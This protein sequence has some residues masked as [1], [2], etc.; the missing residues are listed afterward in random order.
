MAGFPE[1]PSAWGGL[2]A[3][4]DTP[5]KRAAAIGV[6]LVAMA[7]APFA[8][9]TY[10]TVILTNA[11]LYVLLAL[12]LNIVVGYA[13]LLDLG[14]AAFF[15]VGAYTVGITTLHF[16]LSFWLALP[17]AVLIAIIAGIVIGAPTLRLRSDY[18]AIVTLGFGEIV[19]ITARNLRET[20]GASGLIGIDSPWLFGWHIRTPLDFYYVFCVLAILGVIASARL[21]NSRLG[22]AWLYVRH[23][24]DAAEAMGINRVKVKLAAYVVGAIYGSIGG[25]FFAANL[26]AISPESFSF[27]QSVLILMAVILGGM[28]KIPGVI[29]GAFIVILAPELLRDAGDM[30]LLIFAVGLLLI[31]LFRP[32]GIWPARSKQK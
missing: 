30:R 8:F 13:G 26:G 14:F 28:G 21:A 25:A 17:L 1:R 31:M 23:D 27:R 20:G 18:L 11:L 5:A 22:R 9:G 2:S 19:R 15:A 3:I 4:L 16:G 12:G 10:G 29:L 6:I 32:S 24:E 7:V